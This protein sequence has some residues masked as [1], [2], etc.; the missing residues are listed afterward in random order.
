MGIQEHWRR[1]APLV[2]MIYGLP[3]GTFVGA[4]LGWALDRRFGTLPVATVSLTILGFIFGIYRLFQEL[5]RSAHEP[6]LP[7][8]P[9]PPP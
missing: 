6:R 7:R 2:A 4:L 3:V 9:H 1:A 8:P 5:N